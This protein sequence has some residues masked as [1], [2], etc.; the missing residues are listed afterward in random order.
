MEAAPTASQPPDRA[1]AAA[2]TNRDTADAS[3]REEHS[4]REVQPSPRR[5]PRREDDTRS[6][7]AVKREVREAQEAQR[8]AEERERRVTADLRKW[9]EEYQNL[10]VYFQGTVQNHARELEQLSQE[11]H[12]FAAQRRELEETRQL[13]E[14]RTSELR[15]AQSYLAKTDSV[16]H[17]DV[18]SLLQ[19]VNAEILQVCGQIT[20]AYTFGAP[21][22]G[23]NSNANEESALTAARTRVVLVL[24]K[25]AENMLY[26]VRRG[27]YDA[28]CV[29][30]ALQMLFS[31]C[32]ELVASAW[33]VDF[34]RAWDMVF[35]Q[36]PAGT[37]HSPFQ[38]VHDSMVQSGESLGFSMYALKPERLIN[39][40]KHRRYLLD[41]AC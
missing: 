14:T 12:A 28:A 40:K 35:Q 16:S 30:M 24:G 10:A 25:E 20:D 7:A 8:A 32:A 1:P 26:H 27:A 34:G 39:P 37:T 2:S 21:S 18:L 19:N 41:G 6:K 4:A 29:Q 5:Q 11:R 17:T 38:T 31:R 36:V 22:S 23:G 13:L 33:E 15:D 3:T 9:Q